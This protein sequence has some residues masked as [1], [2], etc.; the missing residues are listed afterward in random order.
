M[1]FRCGKSSV[2]ESKIFISSV[3]TCSVSCNIIKS[4]TC[5][6][7]TWRYRHFGYSVW[8][9]YS[10]NFYIVHIE[11]KSFSVICKRVW[12]LFSFKRNSIRSFRIVISVTSVYGKR[13]VI[14]KIN[15][16]KAF[17][18]QIVVCVSWYTDYGAFWK[19]KYFF[20]VYG[21]IFALFN[22]IKCYCKVLRKQFFLHRRVIYRN[23][24]TVHTQFAVAHR[25]V[26]SCG[27][28]VMGILRTCVYCG[29]K[30]VAA[31]VVYAALP[32]PTVSAECIFVWKYILSD[33]YFWCKSVGVKQ[34]LIFIICDLNN[35]TVS[36]RKSVKTVVIRA[37]KFIVFKII[38]NLKYKWTVNIFVKHKDP[39]VCSGNIVHWVSFH[40]LIC[41]CAVGKITVCTC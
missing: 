27:S 15:I 1:S 6:H 25:Q 31:S 21:Y 16:C 3:Y 9:I 28:T 38:C 13:A 20:S 40:S 36:G 37:H 30:S 34:C 5:K 26:G 2:I 22:V 17:G 33:S 18:V 41:H 29:V 24:G 39:S 23:F 19:V 11:D 12:N 7:I 35:R 32:V 8:C 14:K 10:C 4:K